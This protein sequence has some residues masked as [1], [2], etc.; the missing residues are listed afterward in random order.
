[1]NSEWSTDDQ[2]NI[3]GKFDPLLVPYDVSYEN[4]LKEN[5]ISY[6]VDYFWFDP[7]YQGEDVPK[8]KGIVISPDNYYNFTHPWK[9]D[10]DKYL[11]EVWSYDY[12]GQKMAVLYKIKAD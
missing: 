8:L 7:A 3:V 2:G 1:M 9:P 4:K 10:I 5:N 12:Q 6:A 11:E